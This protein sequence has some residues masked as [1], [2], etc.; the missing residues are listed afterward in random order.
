MKEGTKDHPMM[1]SLFILILISA[2]VLWYREVVLPVDQVASNIV[3]CMG[4]GHH[5]E[6]C[7][8]KEHGQR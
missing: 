8:E 7:V 2:S 1:I 4:D 5:Y 6:T 3:S